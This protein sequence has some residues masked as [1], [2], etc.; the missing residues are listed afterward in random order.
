MPYVFFEEDNGYGSWKWETNI[1]VLCYYVVYGDDE[2]TLSI[3]KV[4]RWVEQ[5]GDTLLGKT[6]KEMTKRQKEKNRKR[7]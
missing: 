1:G 2:G 3:K 4:E 7:K 5:N 6:I